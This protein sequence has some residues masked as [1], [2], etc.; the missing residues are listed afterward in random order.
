LSGGNPDEA[1]R[2]LGEIALGRFG[3][4]QGDIGPT[5]VCLA[6]DA[7][8]YVTGQTINVDRGQMIG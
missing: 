2:Y 1:R 8:H 3:G 5:A 4:P 7:A 6:S